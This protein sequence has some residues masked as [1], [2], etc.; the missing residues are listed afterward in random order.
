MVDDINL[1]ALDRWRSES[2][3]D[4]SSL[5]RIKLFRSRQKL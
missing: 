3:L 5:F 4:Q 2:L 1:A